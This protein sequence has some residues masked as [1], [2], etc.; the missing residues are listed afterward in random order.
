[1]SAKS[2]H[3]FCSVDVA[4][5]NFMEMIVLSFVLEHAVDFSLVNFPIH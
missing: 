3:V 4:G 5:E 1:M 2:H